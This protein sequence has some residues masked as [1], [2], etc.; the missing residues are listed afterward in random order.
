MRLLPSLIFVKLLLVAICSQGAAE[1][2]GKYFVESGADWPETAGSGAA[3]TLSPPLSESAARELARAINERLTEQEFRDGP[4]AMGLAETLDELARAQEAAGAVEDARRSRERA[5]HLIRVN[6][7]LYSASQRP[8]LQAI[9]DSL[10]REEDFAALDE[11][12]DYFFRLYGSGQPPWNDL[13]W[14]AAMEYLRWQR[15]ALRRGL[16]GDPMPRL[17]RLHGL[18]E[19][20]LEELRL[21][22]EGPDFRLLAEAVHSQLK[23]F[24]LIEDLIQPQPLFRDQRNGFYRSEDPR[25]FN[26]L[27]E[28]LE[29]LQRTLRG[30]GR[31]L[32]E[33]LLTVIPPQAPEVRAEALLALADWLQWH[34][35]TREASA[36]YESL[37]AELHSQGL[38]QLA[39]NWFSRP[40]PLPDNGVFFPSGPKGGDGPMAVL[41]TVRDNGR[42]SADVTTLAERWQG[43]AIR[44]KRYIAATRFR[45]VVENGRVTAVENVPASYLLFRP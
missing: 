38:Q 40:V 26:L 35:S 43:S 2:Y 14:R 7:G 34:G 10:R 16:D 18:H 27:Q 24:Y 20:L 42:A 21:Q 30:A 28:R 29:N 4:Y 3:A 15:E 9:L 17:L 1:P 44:L 36:L 23:T 33:E 6:E 45:P 5:L 31:S 39:L 11:R 13:R 12:Y 25:D 19:D 22:A 32:I 41:L 37:W 8:I